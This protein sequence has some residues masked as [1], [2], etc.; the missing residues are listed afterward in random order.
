[1]RL[2]PRGLLMLRWLFFTAHLRRILRGFRKPSQWV[3]AFLVAALVA[4]G[5]L[6]FVYGYL[7]E[8]ARP[9]AAIGLPILLVSCLGSTFF[10]ASVYLVLFFQHDSPLFLCAPYARR[11]VL[12]HSHISRQLRFLLILSPLWILLAAGIGTGFSIGMCLTLY[13]YFSML[14]LCGQLQLIVHCSR[15]GSLSPSCLDRYFNKLYYGL[16]L[17]ALAG[18][19]VSGWQTWKATRVTGLTDGIVSALHAFEQQPFVHAATLALYPYAQLMHA[20]TATELLFW[21]ILCMGINS[22]LTASVYPLTD[23]SLEALY[24]PTKEAELEDVVQALPDPRI[25]ERAPWPRLPDFP[26]WSGAQ[27]LTWRHATCFLREHVW[28]IVVTCCIVPAAFIVLA[29]YRHRWAESHSIAMPL[30]L[31]ATALTGLVAAGFTNDF[32]GDFHRMG[33]LKLLPVPGLRAVLAGIAVTTLAGVVVFSVLQG[34]IAFAVASW[35]AFLLSLLLAVPVCLLTSTLVNLVGFWFPHSPKEKRTDSSESW[36]EFL[37]VTCFLFCYL[38]SAVP[39]FILA[40]S[41]LLWSNRS[42]TLAVFAVSLLLLAF[43]VAYLALAVRAFNRV[44][45]SRFPRR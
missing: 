16:V 21:T 39:A 28:R 6:C 18:T 45:V 33:H 27:S 35:S 19:V 3:G 26:T 13:A 38:L 20:H 23:R 24:L 11:Q 41:V 7:S 37:A 9:F 40:H 10:P 12:L 34:L 30:G 1:M 4:A 2:L 31:G 5:V 25:R 42:F 36:T 44:D 32:R 22:L 14:E 43:D 8:I 17:F 15:K 29:Y